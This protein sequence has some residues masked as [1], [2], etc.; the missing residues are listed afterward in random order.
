MVCVAVVIA[1]AMAWTG[2]QDDDQASGGSPDPR[3]VQGSLDLDRTQAGAPDAGTQA[4]HGADRYVVRAPS[5]TATITGK[6]DPP[7]AT[8]ALTDTTERRTARV[9]VARDGTFRAVL[10]GLPPRG[11]VTFRLTATAG[12]ARPWETEIVASREPGGNGAQVR[13]PAGDDSPPTAILVLRNGDRLVSSI[14]PVRD[15]DDP[16]IRV[17]Q[18]SLALTALVHDRDGGTGRVRVSLTYERI[19]LD[20]ATGVKRIHRRTLYFPP[21]EIARVKLPPGAVAPG[22]RRR[23]GRV[24]LD[25][26]PDCAVR[27]K[28]W[29]DATNASGLESFSDQIR[30][31]LGGA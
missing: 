14:S 8:I 22:E 1:A 23:R 10:A 4:G 7:S 9:N 27:G 28:A 26:G 2:C 13:V 30:F 29:A 11:T 18:P 24:R 3:Q 16:P 21:S 19:C 25:S 15:D 6:V 12:K 20:P 17:R 5:D 31:R